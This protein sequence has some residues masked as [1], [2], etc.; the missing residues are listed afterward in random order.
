MDTRASND[1]QARVTALVVTVNSAHC[2]PALGSG[3][4]DMRHVIVIDNASD[5]DTLHQTGLHLPQARV[6][7]Q[8]TNLGFGAANNLGWRAADTEFIFLIKTKDT[9]GIANDCHSMAHANCSDLL[10]H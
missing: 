4:R 7:A 6:L 1:W 3:L 5:D 9:D 10:A 2:M 8:A